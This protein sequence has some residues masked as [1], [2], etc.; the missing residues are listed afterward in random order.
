MTI[1]TMLVRQ[2]FFFL[3]AFL[4]FC[5]SVCGQS[6]QVRGVVTDSLLR[7]IAFATVGYGQLGTQTDTSG[8]FVL[9][10]PQ[11]N[12][13]IR[14][15]VQHI[16]YATLYHR[17]T[18]TEDVFLELRL[19]EKTTALSEV[20][21]EES[22]MPEISTLRIKPTVLQGVPAPFDEF[23]QKLA[24]LGLGIVSNS[25]LSS[26]Y[27]VRGGS[28][29][30]NLVYV[31]GM[32]VYRPF[33]VTAGQQEGLSFVNPEMVES[34]EFSSGGWQPKFGDKLSSVLNI[35]YKSPTQW[36]GSATGGLLGGSAHV[37]GCSQNQKIN[38]IAGIRH[39][40]ARY[41]FNTL[42]TD[43]QYLP[44]FTDFQGL[45]NVRLGAKTTLG[46]LASVA[47]NQYRV[48][49]QSRQT[50]FG[51]FDRQM[52]LF[53]G[54]SGNEIMTYT[55]Y[56]GSARLTQ[57]L[58]NKFQTSWIVSAI[59]TQEREFI[60]VNGAYR[61]C[62]VDNDPN[63]NTFNQCALIRGVGAEY[64]HARNALRATIFSFQNR[65]EW[66]IASHTRLEMG[67]SASSEQIQDQIYEYGVL[68]SAN[69]VKRTHFLATQIGIQSQ[70]LALYLQQQ[71]FL[72]S[73]KQHNLVY[74]V[75]SNYWSLN[76]QW[77]LS[78]RLQYQFVPLDW[79]KDVT[80]QAAAGIY[81][82]PPFY[83]ELRDFEGN[84][85]L[86]LKAQQALHLIT[87]INWAFKSWERPF[88]FIAETYYK[89]LQN[90]I[91][92]DIDNVR[93][94]Y[95]ANNEATAYV[96]GLD[97]RLSGQI[98]KDTESWIALSLMTARENV[99]FD[100]KGYIRRP[101]DQRITA[102][103]YFED[104]LPNNPTWRMNI[105]LMFGSGLPFSV[106]NRPD[107]R[108]VFSAPPYR[109]VDVGFSKQLLFEPQQRLK[110]IWLGVEVLNLLGVENVIS[111]MW[112][113]D[114]V[115]DFQFAVPNG[116]SQRFFNLKAV[117]R[118]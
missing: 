16:N 19:H 79:K 93:L 86:N 24:T 36:G 37:E 95:Y 116:L 40:D 42:E 8:R 72:D 76:G 68:D 110:S 84:L 107:F 70:R 2:L 71:H 47:Q 77:L 62:D 61:L 99:A 4:G 112:V 20:L 35:E 18:P 92:Y 28:F 23:N 38:F 34:I 109:R 25:E 117:V 78:P 59:N 3:I 32:E 101:T 6:V 75:R 58:S 98:I 50:T 81:Q 45:F 94:R 55:T 85:N 64:N 13:R 22:T 65:S 41:L 46:I 9:T 14:L 118:W 103:M 27:Q 54:Y 10:V 51:T 74:G 7:P 114:F 82:Q 67:F 43:G 106:P 96:V 15:Q 88:V 113:R 60:D 66:Q 100:D 115:N 97:M 21:V 30:E 39:K 104:F 80:F 5:M 17:L 69:F 48:V 53:V 33:L 89:R 90:V 31:N 44:R 83:R 52:R 111:Y 73:R 91:P 102:T 57:E 105:R 1:N 29:E 56:Q 63:S 49:P 87:G 12:N 11:Q 108:S 26:T